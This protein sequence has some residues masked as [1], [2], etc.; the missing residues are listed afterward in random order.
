MIARSG[1]WKE[2]WVGA[3]VADK[4]GRIWKVTNM[5]FAGPTAVLQDR[6]GKVGEIPW[7]DNDTPVT[8]YETSMQDAI[9]LI[10]RE[11]DGREV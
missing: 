7:P 4:T 1:T 11:L 9:T 5:I 3:Y 6:D 2:V 10:E 8:I